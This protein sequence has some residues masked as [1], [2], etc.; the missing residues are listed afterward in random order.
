MTDEELA[1]LIGMRPGEDQ[2]IAIR[3]YVSETRNAYGF[4]R[5][6]CDAAKQELKRTRKLLKK[7]LGLRITIEN[8]R[9]A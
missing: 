6:R 5:S 1:T 4:M 2:D 7:A 9:P 8:N 3:R